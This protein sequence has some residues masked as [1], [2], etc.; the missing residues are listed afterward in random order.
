MDA[1]Y[2]AVEERDEPRLRGKPIIV[3]GSPQGRGVVAAASYS[4]RKF[5]VHSAMP[6]AQALRLCPQAV[7]VRPRIDH[8]AA[9][10]HQIRAIFARYTPEIEPLSLDEAFLDVTASTRLFGGGDRIARQIKQAI[11]DEIQLIASVGVAPNKFVAK[12]ASDLRKPDA[13]VVVQAHEVQT[14]LDPLPVG[15]LW[16][17]GKTTVAQFERLGVHRIAQVRQLAPQLLQSHFGKSGMHLW[18]LAQGIDTR[19]VESENQAKSIS[20]ETTF[21]LDVRDINVLEACLSQLTEQVAA[22]LRR[23]GLKGKTLQ[24]KLRYPDFRTITRAHTL[25]EPTD[26]TTLLWQTIRHLFRTNWSTATAIRL[27]GMGVSQFYTTDAPVAVQGDLFAAQSTP[28]PIL[29]SLTDD[30]NRKFG[31]RVLHRGRFR[32]NSE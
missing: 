6:M 29:D 22:R 7:I 23:Y 2:A 31:A 28:R 15:R 14:F 18:Q 3:G 26:S 1:F 27:I 4:A 9:I 32:Q 25:A 24:L 12:I 10:S 8:Y 20:H 30:V 21:A 5:G 19:A 17:A 13:L 11:R 16:G